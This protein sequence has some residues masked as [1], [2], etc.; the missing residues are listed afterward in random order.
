MILTTAKTQH[1]K[2]AETTTPLPKAP[3]T[4]ALTSHSMAGEWGRR[5][6]CPTLQVP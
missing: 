6:R 5:Q 3:I 1:T 4:K 2:H